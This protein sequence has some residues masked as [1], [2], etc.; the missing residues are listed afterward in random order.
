MEELKQTIPSNEQI[1]WEGRPN[2][3][4][5]FMNRIA[6]EIWLPLVWFF[7]SFYILNVYVSLG[8]YI[9]KISTIILGMLI[10]N[11]PVLFWAYRVLVTSI[12]QKNTYYILTDKTIYLKNGRNEIE[13]FHTGTDSF[14]YKN[15]VKQKLHIGLVVDRIYNVG[16]IHFTAVSDKKRSFYIK[17]VNNVEK[18]YDILTTNIKKQKSEA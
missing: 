3:R 5:F 9:F 8:I 17:D 14:P 1:L 2:R 15:V 6:C 4:A 7:I 11:I 18:V 12:A 16:D 10:W 13:V